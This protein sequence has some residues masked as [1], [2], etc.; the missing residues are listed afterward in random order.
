M[1]FHKFQKVAPNLFLNT[2]G[3][4][5]VGL[6]LPPKTY[7]N[8]WPWFYPI[9]QFACKSLQHIFHH[10]CTVSWTFCLFNLHHLTHGHSYQALNWGQLASERHNRKKQ[11]Y[12][13]WTCVCVFQCTMAPEVLLK[14]VSVQGKLWLLCVT[15]ELCGQKTIRQN[16]NQ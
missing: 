4:Q 15:V 1:L 14:V 2:P 6:K 11:H 5:S 12:C 9:I 8:V 16:K 10:V 3:F 7:V 13:L